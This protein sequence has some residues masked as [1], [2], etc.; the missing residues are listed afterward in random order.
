MLCMTK[1]TR[2]AF[3]CRLHQKEPESYSC[4]WRKRNMHFQC[5]KILHYYLDRVWWVRDSPLKLK[6]GKTKGRENLVIS[7]LFSWLAVAGPLFLIIM[8][9]SFA[10]IITK[11]VSVSLSQRVFPSSPTNQQSSPKQPW[12]RTIVGS[13]QKIWYFTSSKF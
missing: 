7:K 9:C 12:W 5:S 8:T 4:N 2:S 11:R 10:G 13:C 6:Q 3:L 1:D